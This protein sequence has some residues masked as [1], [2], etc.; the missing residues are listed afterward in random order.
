MLSHILIVN[1]VFPHVA[2]DVHFNCVVLDCHGAHVELV[3]VEVAGVLHV[4]DHNEEN[5]RAKTYCN[6]C[7]RNY[8]VLLPL[9]F[10][11]HFTTVLDEDH[12]VFFFTA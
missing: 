2:V 12:I 4:V 5:S 9:L 1:E 3:S 10:V 6:S 7:P 8:H 11:G